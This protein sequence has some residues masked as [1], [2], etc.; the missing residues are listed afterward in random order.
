[1]EERKEEE[2]KRERGRGEEKGRK[3]RWKEGRKTRNVFLILYLKINFFR[4]SQ[5]GDVSP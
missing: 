5:D 4:I 3:V 2:R 1:M